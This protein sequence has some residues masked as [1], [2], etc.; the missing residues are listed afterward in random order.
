MP[1]DLRQRAPFRGFGNP[2]PMYHPILTEHLDP[3]GDLHAIGTPLERTEFWLNLNEHNHLCQQRTFERLFPMPD[4]RRR[5]RGWVDE[6]P[7]S[8]FTKRAYRIIREAPR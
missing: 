1:T 2:L 3:P 5:A 7:C 4:P 8:C 6:L